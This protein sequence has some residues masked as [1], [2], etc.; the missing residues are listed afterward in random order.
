MNFASIKTMRNLQFKIYLEYDPEYQGFV[1]DC[2]SLP[3][4][5]SQG[6]TEK[7]E[8][9]EKLNILPCNLTIKSVEFNSI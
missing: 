9:I 6:K 1:A 5:M 8:T 4:C 2:L 3:G 7:E